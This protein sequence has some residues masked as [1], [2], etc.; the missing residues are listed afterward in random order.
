MGS[1]VFTVVSSRL[2]CWWSQTLPGIIPALPSWHQVSH[3]SPWDPPQIGWVVVF[4]SF[5]SKVEEQVDHAVSSYPISPDGAELGIFAGGSGRAN[6]GSSPCTRSSWVHPPVDPNLCYPQEELGAGGV[7]CPGTLQVDILQLYFGF[8]T[9]ITA[10][11]LSRQ[12]HTSSQASASSLAC[13]LV[14]G[15][16]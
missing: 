5:A 11:Q 7:G 12:R 1:D 15:G 10:L 3:W 6:S 13:L 2:W 9:G 14:V 8:P 4:F 16:L